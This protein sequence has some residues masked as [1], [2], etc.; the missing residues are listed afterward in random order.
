[1]L[2]PSSS[3]YFKFIVIFVFLFLGIQFFI[4][5]GYSYDHHILN[6]NVNSAAALPR[7]SNK[8]RLLDIEQEFEETL[9]YDTTTELDMDMTTN[10]SELC[11]VKFPTSGEFF[12]K[13]V[14][15]ILLILF[16]HSW[17]HKSK[18]EYSIT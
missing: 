10:P 17:T 12:F 8:S 7:T 15:S 11:P 1:M 16:I 3:F 13:P 6:L 4:N 14:I 2:Q 5:S 18:L 9:I